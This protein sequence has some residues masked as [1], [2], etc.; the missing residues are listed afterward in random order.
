MNNQQLIAYPQFG[1]FFSS[2]EVILDLFTNEPIPLTLNVDDFTN[3]AEADAS[4]SKSF[5]IPGTKKN[6]NFFNSIYNI[7]SS[8]YFNTHIKTT[9]KIKEN[10]LNIFDGYLQLNDISNKNGVITYNITIY[11]EVVNLKD[12][13]GNKIF[14]DLDLSELNSAYSKINIVNSWTGVLV[15]DN[16]LPTNTFAGTTGDTTTDVLKYPMVNWAKV[17]TVSS[18]VQIDGN[19]VDYFRPWVNALYLLRNI[20]FDAG[21]TFTSSFLS[22]TTFS[23]L[24]VDFNFDNSQAVLD[25]YIYTGDIVGTYTTTATNANSTTLSGGSAALYDSFTDTITV[26]NNGT[27]VSCFGNLYFNLSNNNV[28]ISIAHSN[29]N[30]L[31]SNPTSPYIITNTAVNSNGNISTGFTSD[32]ILDAG[33]TISIKIKAASGAGGSAPTVSID[34]STNDSW[35]SWDIDGGIANTNLDDILLGFRGD[36]SQWGYFKGIIDMFKLVILVDENNPTNLL[37]EPYIDWVG[38]GNQ[39]DWTNKVDESEFKFSPIDGLARNIEFNYTEDSN[40]WE[41]ISLNNPY[42]WLWGFNFASGIEIVDKDKDEV[43]I[44]PFAD[45]LV[46]DVLV[47]GTVLPQ[48]LDN[49]VA[50]GSLSPLRFWENEMRILYDN[51]VHAFTG[52]NYSMGD[53]TSE[54]DRLLFTAVKDFPITSSS[55]SLRFSFAPESYSNI[56]LLNNLY[57]TY[58]GSYIDELYHKDTRIIKVEAYLT[59]EDIYNINFNDTILIKS[60]EYRI[61]KIDYR[62]GSMSKLQLITIRNL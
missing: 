48:I 5:D 24:F 8:S 7:N 46:Q 16:P 31:Y 62:A 12:S 2:D 29:T 43:V 9:V 30:A 60:T 11:S 34:T 56:P 13:I 52:A 49:S 15:L 55:K 21:Y 58:W 41:S 23:K 19:V 6:N 37:I 50:L 44:S 26:V 53:F 20:F 17:N 22:S 25:N 59:A 40:S 10:T 42:K 33:D 57:M 1:G 38:A 4:Y 35:I 3:A 39:L 47:P 61:Y 51:G 36:T 27:A 45:T 14:R 54:T 32:I 18:A 28:E